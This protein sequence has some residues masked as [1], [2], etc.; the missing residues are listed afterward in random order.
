MKKSRLPPILAAASV[1]LL[2]VGTAGPLWRSTEE[3]VTTISA[4]AVLEPLVIPRAEFD[5]GVIAVRRE[6]HVARVELLNRGSVP[7]ILAPPD[8][9][10]GCTVASLSRSAIPAGGSATLTVTIR[11]EQAES[12]ESHVTIDALEPVRA[13]RRVTLSWRSVAPRSFEPLELNLGTL[14]PGQTAE[15]TAAAV[16]ARP[17]AAG[18]VAGVPPAGG[19]FSEARLSVEVLT[20]V[21]RRLEAGLSVH[22]RVP[23][24]EATD[25]ADPG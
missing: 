13:R 14:R 10:C 20:P 12:R 23:P 1:A 16:V 25:D 11:P 4:A 21:R 9:S 3:R 24:D 22:V 15:A 18:R 2:I 17:E 7:L 8:S 6:P 5:F 19:E